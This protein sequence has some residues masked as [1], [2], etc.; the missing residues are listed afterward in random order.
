MEVNMILL[1]VKDGKCIPRFF[2]DGCGGP[3]SEDGIVAYVGPDKY[4]ERLGIAVFHREKCLAARQE[5]RGIE[6]YVELEDFI[7]T[8]LENTLRGKVAER[9]KALPC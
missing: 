2:C 3:I 1:Q 7:F 8:V 4:T 9:L 5:R 6:V